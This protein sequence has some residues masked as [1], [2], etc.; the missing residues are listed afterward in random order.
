MNNFTQNQFYKLLTAKLSGDATEEQLMQLQQQLGLHPEWRFLYDQMMKPSAEYPKEL[1]DQAYAAHIVKMQL[2]GKLDADLPSLSESSFTQSANKGIYRKMIYVIAVAASIIG[3]LF[4]IKK[5]PEETLKHSSASNEVTTRKGSK[6]NIKLPDGTQVWLNADSRISYTK[7][8]GDKTREVTLTGEA[9]F[10]VVHDSV[11]PFLIHTGNAVIKV[12]GTAFNVRNYPQDKS[13][14]TSLIRGKIE[15]TLIDRPDEKIIL[16]PLEKLII[17]NDRPDRD[18]I[19]RKNVIDKPVLTSVTYTMVDSLVA[20]TSWMKDKMV[21]INLPLEKIAEELERK[22]AVTVHFNSAT[23]R[24]YRY[25]GVFG[26]EELDEI[27]EI[28][29]QSRKIKYSIT[30]KHVI[31]E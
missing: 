24:Q 2:N 12:L 8:F 16:K 22:F 28:L 29:K 14:E 18:S 9:Y 21:F 4:I 3:F 17:R 25:T 26:T 30:N 11:H 27:L 19:I 10:D 1:A 13:L 7:E 6:S 23:T 15:V 20:E 5:S 31:I